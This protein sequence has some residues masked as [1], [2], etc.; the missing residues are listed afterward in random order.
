MRKSQDAAQLLDIGS[1][2]LLAL[3]VGI[4]LLLFAW[5]IAPGRAFLMELF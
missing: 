4:A 5:S 2:V 3:F 1:M